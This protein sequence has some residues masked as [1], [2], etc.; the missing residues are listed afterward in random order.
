[1][2]VNIL[3]N[4]LTNV[5][6]KYIC[7]AAEYTYKKLSTLRWVTAACLLI[8]LAVSVPIISRMDITLD[9]NNPLEEMQII[10][11][12]NA[13]YEV[14]QDKSVLKRLG[15]KGNADKS[16]IGEHIA[17][18]V[19][20]YPNDEKSQYIATSEI[21]N[22]E[23]FYYK[24]NPC[25]AI[26]ILRDNDKYFWVA[27][28]NYH[29]KSNESMPFEEIL[30]VY[31]INSPDD[32]ASISEL[33][34]GWFEHE[35]KSVTEREAIA[36]FYN[37]LISLKAYSNDEFQRMT[38]S[39]DSG[40]IYT[41]FADSTRYLLIKTKTGVSIK[42]QYSMKYGWVV[43]SSTLSYYKM[44]PEIEDLLESIF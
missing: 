37:A 25:K 1:M 5:N 3:N 4:A 36:R 14:V 19:K 7:E 38:F 6:E 32:I 9:K 12:N 11:F 27:F 26:S 34:T 42:I 22:L 15:I 43:G 2:N 28:C 31:N 23:L 33:K 39:D 24:E 41:Q 29:T 18:L 35:G 13:Y 40:S 16:M 21:T 8:I 17:Y 20:E 30:K 44:T 10:D